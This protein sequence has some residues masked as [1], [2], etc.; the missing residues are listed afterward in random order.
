MLQFFMKR[1]KNL[2]SATHLLREETGFELKILNIKV[3]FRVHI[4]LWFS[5][6]SQLSE[7]PAAIC[8]ATHRHTLKDTPQLMAVGWAD[9]RLS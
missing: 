4:F 8:W 6:F 1:N 7:Q 2:L 5:L 3:S 9:C